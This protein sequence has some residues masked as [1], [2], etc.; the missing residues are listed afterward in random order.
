M[1]F[2]LCCFASWS[3]TGANQQQQQ[4]QRQVQARQQQQLQTRQQL[5]LEK[6][7]QQEE[8]QMSDVKANVCKCLPS[9]D[10]L[11]AHTVDLLLRRTSSP[12]RQALAHFRSASSTD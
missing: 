9:V 6:Q 12:L 4:Q 5:Q 11:V 1:L 3:A 7:Q 8:L 10:K 2:S